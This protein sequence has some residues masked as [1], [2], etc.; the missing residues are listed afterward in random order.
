[1]SYSY[2]ERPLHVKRTLVRL[3]I[4]LGLVAAAVIAWKLFS[5]PKPVP[6]VLA[7]VERGRVEET[8][9]NTR[10]GTIKACRRAGLAPQIG[11]QVAEL[12]VHKGDRV[13]AGALLMKLWNED[14]EAQ[15]RLA[16]SEV[17]ASAARTR[18]ACL[19]A[20]LAGKEAARIEQLLR[21]G[22]TS[23]QSADEARTQAEA[24]AASCAAARAAE[25][26][27]G[28][29]VDAAR[30]AL[31]KTVLRAPFAGIVAEVNPEL[32][33]FV[34]PS[35]IG[36]PTPPAIDLWEEGC[37]YVVA[38]LDEIDAPRVRTG[39]PARVTLDAFPDRTFPGHVSRI[40]PYVLD[41][42]RQSRTVDVEARLD[43]PASIPNLLPG[44]SADMEVLLDAR[45]NVL[46]IPT[47]ALLEGDRVL[48]YRDGRLAEAKVATGIGNWEQTEIVSGLTAGERVVVSLDREGVR[49]G[50]AAVP[51][52]AP[53]PA[54]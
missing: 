32:G 36:I 35:P 5:R 17:R 3:S 19:R 9:A 8:V 43:D 31:A 44:Y 18:E 45:E 49:A 50:V 13:A 52:T 54:K 24:G 34:T 48:V 7:T 47:E 6:V 14:L 10:A 53:A 28:S 15:L 51:E 4:A 29:A 16:E 42:E 46:R 38:P 1:M 20:D 25:K 23:Q 33:E 11:G 39:M 21:E 30:A 22:I 41:R 26:Q 40:A 2:A 27:A 37:L 12:T